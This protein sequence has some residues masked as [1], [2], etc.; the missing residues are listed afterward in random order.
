M[1]I[2]FN[3]NDK[4]YPEGEA[5]LSPD[6]RSFRYGDGL[7]ETMKAQNCRVLLKDLHF[8]RLFSGMEQ[9]NFEPPGYLTPSFLEEKIAALCKKN[10]QIKTARIRLTVY[11]GDGV[12]PDALNNIPGFIIQ[13]WEINDD[14][15]LNADGLA[16]DVYPHAR[17]SCDS[18]SNLKSNNFLPYIMAGIYAKR[19]NLHDCLLL[20]THE[21]I[22][23]ST[24]ANLFIIKD[25][26]IYT[27]PLTEG[28][29]AGVTRRW[30]LENSTSFPF[31]LIEKPIT[32]DQVINADEIFLTNAVRYIN[33]VKQFGT[34]AYKNQAIQLIQQ[35]FNDTIY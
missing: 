18:F 16:V 32:K 12:L 2:F 34:S 24:I 7:F 30:M 28:C 5:V 11:R 15:K 1:G 19:N 33:W 6:N 31:P 17:K 8:Q 4:L 13:T 25:N 3:L 14:R 29:V 21:R 23:D 22:C 27:P 20:N 10:Q 35:R 26:I 9:L